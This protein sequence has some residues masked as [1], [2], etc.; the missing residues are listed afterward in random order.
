[1]PA[2]KPSSLNVR[3]DS[4]KSQ[5]ARR[6][7]EQQA[8]PLE[9]SQTPPPELRGHKAAQALWRKIIKQQNESEVRLI[10]A[11]DEELLID[12][13]LLYEDS[14]EIM[15]RRDAIGKD[16]AQ[17]SRKISKMNPTA[18]TVKV[19]ADLWKQKNAADSNWRSY[20]AR[21]DS[22]LAHLRELRRSIYREPRARAGAV[23]EA[24]EPEREKT[25]MEKLLEM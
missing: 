13:C 18:E 21:L 24:K 11:N 22:H 14:A 25:E 16:A 1:M 19:Y 8:A 2:R 23:I 17:L 20:S 4:K 7:A 5:R 6:F 10:T 15:Q 9:I 12:Y 3:K